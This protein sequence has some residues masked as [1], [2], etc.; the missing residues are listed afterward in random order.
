MDIRLRSSLRRYVASNDPLDAVAF[1]HQLL[2]AYEDPTET[3][4]EF[5]EAFWWLEAHPA[6]F[7]ATEHT[8]DLPGFF[9][10]LNIQVQKVNPLTKLIDGDESLNTLVEIWLSVGPWEEVGE[11]EDAYGTGEMSSRDYDLNCG[12]PSY[13][14]AIIEMAR[15]VNEHYGDY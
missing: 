10:S 4:N 8:L 12:G 5:Y 14:E 9:D 3:S 6:F 15:L 1:V 7:H 13:E 2:R 11:D